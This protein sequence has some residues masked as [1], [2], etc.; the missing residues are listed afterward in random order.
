[1]TRPP[2][3]TSTDSAWEEWGQRDP[4][5]GVLTDSKFR[6]STID[7]HSRQEFFDSGESHVQRV[8]TTIRKYIDSGFAPKTILDF[9]CGVG[10]LLPPFAAIANEVVGLDVSPSMLLEAARNRDQRQLTNVKLL[11]S[12][13]DLSSLT[14]TFDLVHSFIVLQHIPV[15]RGRAIFGKLLQH[16]SPGGIG[17][18]H[19]TYS[20][21]QFASTNG[22]APPLSSSS[23]KPRPKLPDSD[24]E[25]QMNPYNLNEILFLMQR[26]GIARVHIEFTDH[27]GELGVFLFF[28]VSGAEL[29]TIAF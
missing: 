28:S 5:F 24:P 10:R 22:V 25:I 15:S 29:S 6:R 3:D 26:R 20:K 11:A 17:A 16:V 18:F 7:E 9:G 2:A 19:V 14:G 12:D 13:D 1:M 4:Y 8:L 23:S 21:A 27:G